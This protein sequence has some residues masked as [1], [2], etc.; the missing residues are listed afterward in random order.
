M[1]GSYW[2]VDIYCDSII[3][4]VH[5]GFAK[6]D[7]KIFHLALEVLNV[8]LQEAIVV[9][10]NWGAGVLGASSVGIRGIHFARDDESSG[11]DFITDCREVIDIV[12]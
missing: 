2:D 9:G 6:P 5:V 8:G 11:Y 12:V 7:P 4:P 1:E 3:E 10:D